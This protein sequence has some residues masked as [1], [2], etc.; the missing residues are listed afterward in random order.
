MPLCRCAEVLRGRGGICAGQVDGADP[1]LIAHALEGGGVVVT[2]ELF[3]N[4]Y[5]PKIPNVCEHFGVR[6]VA[7]YKGLKEAGLR[8]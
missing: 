4:G 2:H 8:L 6:Y 7:A 5:D 3:S 1:W